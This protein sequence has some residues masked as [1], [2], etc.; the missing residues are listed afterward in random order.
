MKTHA[1]FLERVRRRG[2]NT[3]E[4]ALTLPVFLYLMLGV[5]DYGYL[6][7]AH[8]VLDAA[9]MEG[10]REGAI[11]D[12]YNVAAVD[13]VAEAKAEEIA[14]GICAGDCVYTCNDVGNP[15]EREIEC[16]LRWNI[17]PLVGLVPYPTQIQSKGRQLLEWQRQR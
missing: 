11:T 13:A 15:P 12:P 8:A 9:A 6:M 5:V 2:G 1:T 3:V 16:D 4:F 10:T 7:M 14:S 17:E